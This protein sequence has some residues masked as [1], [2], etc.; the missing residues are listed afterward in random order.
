MLVCQPGFK[1]SLM[2]QEASN[3]WL[4]K[5]NEFVGGWNPVHWVIRNGEIDNRDDDR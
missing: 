2:N 4:K 5:L 1:R 3:N